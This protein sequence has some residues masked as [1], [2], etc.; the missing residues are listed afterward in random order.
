MH[1]IV[2]LGFCTRM[3]DV[4]RTSIC[5]VSAVSREFS[6]EGCVYYRVCISRTDFRLKK[7]VLLCGGPRFSAECA[8]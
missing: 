4:M 1:L 3:Q 8:G 6:G 2:I 7:D 5:E